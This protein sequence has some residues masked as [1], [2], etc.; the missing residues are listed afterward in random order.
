MRRLAVGA[1]KTLGI[2]ALVA[3]PL[4]VYWRSGDVLS[5]PVR[6]AA[7]LPHAAAYL[8]FLWL[9]GRSLVARREPLIT[10]VARRVHGTLEPEIEAYTRGVTLAWCLFF[11]AQLAASVLLFVFAPVDAWLLFV[12]LL[13]V[14]LLALMFLAEYLYRVI[15]YP[16]HPR[17]PIAR[18]ARAF[19]EDAF[20]S[21]GAKAR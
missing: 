13:N 4:L 5:L 9:F 15:R 14:P 20:V 6:L 1:V 12:G 7:G 19:I 21:T 17:T 8:F 3:S 2:L 11:S 18:M 10:S 16:R